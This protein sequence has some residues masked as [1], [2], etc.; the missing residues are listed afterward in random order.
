MLTLEE[1]WSC[2]SL[3]PCWPLAGR[4]RG[5]SWCPQPPDSAGC[6]GLFPIFLAER[7]KFFAPCNLRNIIYIYVD[8]NT[9]LIILHICINTH[10]YSLY[11]HIWSYILYIYMFLGGFLS[12]GVTPISSS[13]STMVFFHRKNPPLAEQPSGYPQWPG[14]SLA[15]RWCDVHPGVILKWCEDL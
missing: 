11:I 3:V 4:S 14:D 2:F 1:L 13:D 5:S 10:L 12:H 9:L 8:V 15:I 7:F 6:S